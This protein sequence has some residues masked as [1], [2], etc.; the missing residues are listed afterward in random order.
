MSRDGPRAGARTATVCALLGSVLQLGLAPPLAAAVE[1][2]SESG[3]VSA[4][5]SIEPE[6]PRIGDPIQLLLQVEAAPGVELLMPEFGDAL[7]RYAIVDF[8]PSEGLDDAG[9]TVARQRYTLQ[10][11]RSGPQ[12]I[13]PLLVEFIDRR[14]GRTPTPED[15]DAYELLTE[16]LE[17]EVETVLA[18]DDL[19]DLVP[20]LAELGPL[21]LPGAPVWPWAVAA[22]AAAAIA[23]PF[24]RRAVLARSALGRRRS[25]YEVARSELDALLYG[26]RPSADAVD[27]FYVALSGIVRRYLEDRFRLRSPEQTTEEFVEDLARSPDLTRPHQDLLREFLRDADLVKFAHHVPDASGT[28]ASIDLAQRFLEKTRELG[29]A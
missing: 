22:L 25:A 8:A 23:T 24:A 11:S 2:S 16:R 13:P 5:V 14:P 19:L 26:P 10:A 18:S 21:E 12:S 9:R 29:H 4:R 20:A 15:A 1:V 17:F 27:A 7:D 6:A 3:P 28:K